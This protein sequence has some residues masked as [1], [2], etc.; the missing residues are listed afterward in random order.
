MQGGVPTFTGHWG[1]DKPGASEGAVLNVLNSAF[2]PVLTQEKWVSHDGMWIF[3][4][5]GDSLL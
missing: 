3:I 1:D 5:P 4:P 2:Y